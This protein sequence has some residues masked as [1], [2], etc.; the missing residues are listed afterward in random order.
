MWQ[1]ESSTFTPPPKIKNIDQIVT[2]F[3][4]I[5]LAAAKRLETSMKG[6]GPAEACMQFVLYGRTICELDKFTDM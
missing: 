5:Q 4:K 1:A 3:S 2:P 6:K